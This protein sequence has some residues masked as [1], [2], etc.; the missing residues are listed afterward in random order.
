MVLEWTLGLKGLAY[1]MTPGSTFFA[2][3]SVYISREHEPPDI[4]YET[5]A[6]IIHT[7]NLQLHVHNIET[8]HDQYFS[9]TSE[10]ILRDSKPRVPE[11]QA[12]HDVSVYETC[13]RVIH[14]KSTQLHVH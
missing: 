2:A 9:L 12:S 3:A 10:D 1:S 11:D 5:C 6:C 13:A 14:T 4:L 7:I 8:L